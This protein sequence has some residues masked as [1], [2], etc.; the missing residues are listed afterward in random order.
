V[1][2]TP[3]EFLSP[4][5]VRPGPLSLALTELGVRISL[6]FPGSPWRDPRLYAHELVGDDFWILAGRW[7]SFTAK[8]DPRRIHPRLGW[9]Q[10]PL[11]AENPMGLVPWTRQR[12]ARDGR[13]KVL[14][15][16]DSYVAGHAGEDHGLPQLLERRLAAA[17]EDVDVLH[18]GV[19]GYGTDQ[20]HLLTR[21]TLPLVDR[22]QVVL[23]GVMT[24]SFDRA[25]QRVRSYQKPVLEVGE[26][27]TLRVSNVP[28]CASPEAYFAGRRPSFRSYARAALDYRELK[29]AAPRSGFDAK[30]ALNRAI[31]SANKALAA[32]HGA[33]L[34]YVLF[35]DWHQL[36]HPDRRDR[37]FARELAAQGIATLDTAAPLLEHARKNGTDASELYVDGHHNERGNEVIAAA[38]ATAVERL[39]GLRQVRACMP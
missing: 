30:A 34:M 6:L 28:I 4:A 33:T 17:G 39:P 32:E 19:G 5:A 22:P 11:L 2:P 16:G 23:M 10:G 29:H 20:M 13:R 15:F 37:F 35:R 9:T 21:E 24:F 25:A 18:L 26:G 1:L 12:L 38:L 14:F 27:G 36:H 3:D 31:I 8:I 7:D